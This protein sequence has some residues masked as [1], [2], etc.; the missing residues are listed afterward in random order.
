MEGCGPRLES[1]F[2]VQLTNFVTLGQVSILPLIFRLLMCE[3]GTMIAPTS[4]CCDNYMNSL[5][6]MS[7]PYKAS[8]NASLKW[9]LLYMS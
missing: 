7:D 1:K 2:F 5:C 3:V 9:K 8:V 4:R 6:W